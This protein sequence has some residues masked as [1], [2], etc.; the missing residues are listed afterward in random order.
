MP[1]K[2]RH[3]SWQLRPT[4]FMIVLRL[5]TTTIPVRAKLGI[6]LSTPILEDSSGR[7]RA[8]VSVQVNYPLGPLGKTRRIL[9]LCLVVKCRVALSLLLRT[10]QGAT[11]RMSC[12]VW[13]SR[14]THITLF[15]C[16][17]LSG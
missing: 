7:Q 10:R 12:W 13:P 4:A 2:R 5:L 6:Y 14:L 17:L 1:L 9:M 15:I 11:T 8:P 16:L 3:K